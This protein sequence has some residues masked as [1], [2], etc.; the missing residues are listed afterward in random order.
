MSLLTPGYWPSTYWPK[1]YWDVSYWPHY[2]ISIAPVLGRIDLTIESL[3]SKRTFFSLTPERKML[4]TTHKR[5]I[6]EK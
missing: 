5:T 3:T 6:H 4:S 2:G 1:S